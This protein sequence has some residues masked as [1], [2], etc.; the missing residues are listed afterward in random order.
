M[1][2]PDTWTSGELARETGLTVRALHHYEGL[3][4]LRPFRDAGGRRC[5][6]P[7]DVRRLHQI[8][9][10][11]GFGLTLSEI[12]ELLDGARTDLGD[13]LRRQLTQTQERIAAA[14][15]LRRSLLGVLGRLAHRAEPF[16]E[17]LIELVE[18]MISMDHQFT[19]EQLEQMAQQRREMMAKLSPEQLIDLQRGREEAASR[20]SDEELAEMQR[21]RAAM[22]SD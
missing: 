4:L 12:G 1:T 13:M 21:H 20:L 14:Q 18:V 8:I 7:A 2:R 15:R 9:A 10:L 5:Y 3:G 17:E 16:T 19:P 11:R 6:S 22:M